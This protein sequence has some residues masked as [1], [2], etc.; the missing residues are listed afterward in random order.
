MNKFFDRWEY[1]SVE[2]YNMNDFIPELNTFFSKIGIPE[3]EERS[4][5]FYSKFYDVEELLFILSKT[6][7][8]VF[9]NYLLFAGHEFRLIEDNNKKSKTYDLEALQNAQL[10]LFLRKCTAKEVDP[11]IEIYSSEKERNK[12]KYKTGTREIISILKNSIEEKFRIKYSLNFDVNNQE[13]KILEDF[14]S[15]QRKLVIRRGKP[16]KNHLIAQFALILLSL[17]YHDYAIINKVEGYSNK[18]CRLIHDYLAFFKIIDDKRLLAER[19]NSKGAKSKITPHNYI[20]SLVNNYRKSVKS[21][22]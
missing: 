10:L 9:S 15:K 8:K 18:D 16:Q 22:S 1:Y 6:P 17:I 3:Y 11:T 5:D 12:S 4:F 21:I 7:L 19:L 2:G 20:R 14:I 13:N